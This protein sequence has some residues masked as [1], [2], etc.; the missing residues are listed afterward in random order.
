MRRKAL[1]PAAVVVTA[2][3]TY[4]GP[5]SA[6]EF[7]YIRALQ[8]GPIGDSPQYANLEKFEAEAEAG[9]SRV[10][11]SYSANGDDSTK[12]SSA[13]FNTDAAIGGGWEPTK[14]FGMTA[15]A[16]STLYSS[17]TEEGASIQG[18]PKLDTGLY[19]HELDIFG[20]YKAAPFIFGGGIGVL[21][22]GSEDRTFNYNGAN[23]RE[24]VS[25]AAM[26]VL[27]L[28]GGITTK[29]VDASVGFR[30]FSQGDATVTGTESTGNNHNFDALRRNPGEIHADGRLK[31]KEAE[32]AATIAYVLTEQAS[33]QFDE[34][35][36]DYQTVGGKSLRQTGEGTRD[37][38]TFRIGVG[39]K[40]NPVKEV[41]LLGGLTYTAPS[42]NQEQ[43]A[44]LE[45]QNLGGIRFDLGTNLKFEKFRGFFRANYTL[46]NSAS[47]TQNDSNR[48][49]VERN[50]MPPLNNQDG[51]KMTQGSW[52][53]ALGGGIGL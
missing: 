34:W 24:Q 13:Q 20:F 29:M 47:F 25:S 6:I 43:F 28:F 26:P 27:N 30:I 36:M 37:D 21:L 2:L 8:D 7:G 4:A 22:F 14:N 45:A 11:G 49:N 48:T 46:G 15:Y 40:F 32:A 19:R 10:Y 17:F 5:A 35:S 50:Q 1:L 33:P 9:I 39:G 23:Y 31:F 12:V 38:N 41:G 42:Y 3:S 52:G 51:V 16:T 44:S 18:D 53:L